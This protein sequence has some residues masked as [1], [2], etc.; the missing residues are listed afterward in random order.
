MEW[1][2][3]G[4]GGENPY[5]HTS[6][7]FWLNI[8]CIWRTSAYKLKSFCFMGLNLSPARLGAGFSTFFSQF[9]FCGRPY[10][11]QE[12]KLI[13]CPRL[14]CTPVINPCWQQQH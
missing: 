2:K 8:D 4:E 14:F 10:D 7:V 13:K 9:L 5:F 1:R 6:G 3:M 12:K 11:H